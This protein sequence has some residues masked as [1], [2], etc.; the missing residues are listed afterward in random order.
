MKIA[1]LGLKGIPVPA[2]VEVVAEQVG[3][4]LVQRGHQVTVYVRSH[5]TPRSLT[6]YK[7]MRLVHLPSIPTKHFDAITHSF[8][9]SF[10]VLANR[11]DIL[12]IHGTGSSIFGLHPR[13]WGIK[14]VVQSHGLDWQRAK[15]GCFAR[16]Y[17]RLTDYSTVHFPTAATA[18]SQKMT[19]YYQQFSPREVIYIP[20]GIPSVKRTAPRLIRQ[21]GLAGDDYLLFAARLVP[22]KGA[23]YLIEAYQRFDTTKKLVIAGDDS[24]NSS[25]CREL[26]SR[27][28]KNVI[29]TGFVQGALLQEFLSNAYLYILPSE[30]EG[31]SIGLLEAMGYGN[32]VLTSDIPENLEVIGDAGFTFRTRSVDDL[33]TEMRSLL[34][35]EELVCSRRQ[36][37]QVRV[38]NLFDWE[39]VTDQFE[40]LYN[41]IY[42]PRPKIAL[43]LSKKRNF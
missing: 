40:Q 29:F 43:S 37:S 23:H 36:M 26:K 21:Y 38:Q 8:L 6:E 27:A 11:P 25:Y 2:G 7:G 34:Q 31:L 33:E 35:N 1:M 24:Y 9:A 14:T 3:S 19:Q 16:M 41:N 4:R 17:L 15:W 39:A 13:L 28:G 18:V 30:V 5:Y 20:N 42:Y 22:E 32:C 12:H 10:A